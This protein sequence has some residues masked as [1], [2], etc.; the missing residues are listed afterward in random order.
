MVPSMRDPVVL[1]CDNIGAIANAKDPRSHSTAKHI[2]R[3]YHVIRQYVNSGDVRICKVHTDLN[4][5]DPL[6]KPLPQAKHDQHQAC[7]GVRFLPNVN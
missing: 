6:T 3:R 1:Y 2:P 7:M 4:V 5:A